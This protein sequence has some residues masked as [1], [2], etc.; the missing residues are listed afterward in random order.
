MKNL[1][2]WMKVFGLLILVGMIYQQLLSMQ[3]KLKD[4]NTKI[5][6]AIAQISEAN[7]KIA[8]IETTV[9]FIRKDQK[10][11]INTAS[12]GTDFVYSTTI[13]K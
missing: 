7:I 4:Q 3:D 5:E 9:E 8:R 12:Q 13:R 11:S 10:S 6:A 2:P 1:E